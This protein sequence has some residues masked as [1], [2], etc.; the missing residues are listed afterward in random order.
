MFFEVG[1]VWRGGQKEDRSQ[2]NKT[3]NTREGAIMIFWRDVREIRERRGGMEEKIGEEKRK[4]RKTKGEEGEG[5]SAGERRGS[6]PHGR[7][8]RSEKSSLG[9]GTG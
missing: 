3:R 4:Q 7:R 5:G 6:F 1:K 9:R 8:R 2:R